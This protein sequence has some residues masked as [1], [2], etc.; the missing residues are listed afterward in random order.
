MMHH[1]RCLQIYSFAPLLVL[2]LYFVWIWIMYQWITDTLKNRLSASH[3]QNQAIACFA[4]FAKQSIHAP[5]I[6]TPFFK[7]HK[8]GRLNSS[9]QKQVHSWADIF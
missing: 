6:G 7:T 5:I 9:P 1:H 4:L 8:E 3:V 2:P